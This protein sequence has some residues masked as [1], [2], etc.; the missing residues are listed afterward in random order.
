MRFDLTDLRLFLS[1]ADSGSITKGAE[2]AHLA[3]ASASE[4]IRG[5]EETLGVALLARGRRGVRPTPAGQALLH[6]ARLMLEQHER[7]KGELGAYARGLKAHVHVLCNSAAISEF[8]PEALGPY[9]ADHPNVDVELEERPSYLIVQNVAQGLADLGIVA[10][11]VDLGDLQTF[12]FRTDRLVVVVPRRHALARRRHVAL[13]DVVHRDFIGLS[14]GSALQDHLGQHAARLGHAFKLRVR[15]SG[16]DA[17]CRM[18]ERGAGIGIVPDTAARR[19]RRAMAISIVPLSDP[20]ALRHL[21][22]CVRR[23]DALPAHAQALVVHL[24][25]D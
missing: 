4:R 15:V 12:P 21:T 20:W 2:R 22:L 8:L 14:A 19:C 16:F 11:T 1:V 9:L 25:A 6:H 3:L 7:M 23:L 5:M 10:D 17:V 24:R 18:V 13:R